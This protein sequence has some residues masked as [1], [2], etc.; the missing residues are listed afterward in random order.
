METQGG[1]SFGEEGG[2]PTA[3]ATP[4]KLGPE[5]VPTTSGDWLRSG[6]HSG[7]ISQKRK[8]EGELGA[9]SGGY[10]AGRGPQSHVLRVGVQ[11]HA[12]PREPRAATCPTHRAGCPPALLPALHPSRLSKPS[13]RDIALS[14]Q[15]LLSLAQSSSP[16]ER[17]AQLRK[18][19]K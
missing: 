11:A 6:D 1:Q 9:L 4:C 10:R 13:T 3:A 14:P 2:M 5:N 16:K 15:L 19:L 17:Q 7:G 8:Q 18:C 12:H